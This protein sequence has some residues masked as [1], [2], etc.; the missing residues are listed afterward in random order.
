MKS[1][2]IL[3]FTHFP[4]QNYDLI[5]AAATSTEE[6]PSTLCNHANAQHFRAFV[7]FQGM[8]RPPEIEERRR[9]LGDRTSKACCTCSKQFLDEIG[10]A[11]RERG[12]STDYFVFRA[13]WDRYRSQ[14]RLKSDDEGQKFLA[15]QKF[16][17][18]RRADPLLKELLEQVI[19]RYLPK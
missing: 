17:Q 7:T 15:F 1:N 10:R 5:C 18:D 14:A 13:I 19:E 2:Q 6:P 3:A 12:E 8:P 16:L 4:A 9:A 11:A